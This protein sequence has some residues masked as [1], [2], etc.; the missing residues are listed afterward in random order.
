MQEIAQALEQGAADPIPVCLADDKDLFGAIEQLCNGMV[1]AGVH[2]GILCDFSV[3]VYVVLRKESSLNG[4]AD[5]WKW[6]ASYRCVFLQADLAA[7]GAP[8]YGQLFAFA[9][10]EALKAPDPGWKV[11]L[12]KPKPPAQRKEKKEKK[13]QHPKKGKASSSK[14]VQSPSLA[15]ETWH[16]RAGANCIRVV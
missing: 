11:N 16:L 6:H 15:L 2:H 3:A 5:A 7:D 13:R 10:Q 12:P 4:A 8:T 14:C 1:I 9:I